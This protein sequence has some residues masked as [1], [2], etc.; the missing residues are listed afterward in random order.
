MTKIIQRTCVRSSDARWVFD[1]PNRKKTKRKKESWSMRGVTAWTH[2]IYSTKHRR[3]KR[4]FGNGN[5]MQKLFGASSR[6]NYDSIH[7]DS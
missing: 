5:A 2:R 1:I 4:M 6:T 3:K 7:D